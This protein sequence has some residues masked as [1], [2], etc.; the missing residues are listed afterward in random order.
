M[1]RN[2]YCQDHFLKKRS[3][4]HLAIK[5]GRNLKKKFLYICQ[6]TLQTGQTIFSVFNNVRKISCPVCQNTVEVSVEDAQTR[7]TVICPSCNEAVPIKNAPAGRK[8]VRCHCNALLVAKTTSSRVGC[9]RPTCAKE[10]NL[11]PDRAFFINVP[12]LS[13]VVCTFCRRVFLCNTIYTNYPRC[14][15]CR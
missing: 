4:L 15:H 9:P 11:M 13:R 7:R 2:H 1:K 12:E 10:V 8:Y 5:V 3:Y 14:P 6:K